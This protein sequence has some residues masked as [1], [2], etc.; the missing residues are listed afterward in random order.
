VKRMMILAVVG[1]AAIAAGCTSTPVRSN[2]DAY[3]ELLSKQQAA[4]SNVIASIAGAA[5]A[6]TDSRCVEHVA[7]MAAMAAAGGRGSNPIAPPPRELSGAEKFAQVF[8]AMS[9]L[10]GTVVT[11]AV[12][13][14]QSDNAARTAEAQYGYLD[15]VLGQALGGM[16]NVAGNAVPSITVGGNY[17]DTFGDNY[18]GGD[19]TQTDVAGHLIS[20]DS[21]VIGDRNYNSGRQDSAGPYDRTCTGDGCQPVNPDPAGGG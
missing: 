17:G 18:T 13:W 10:F 8:S 11:G 7:S 16:A 19:R 6:C 12:Q 3:G 1:F 2:Y 5:N 20:G 4:E 9:P 15:S 14:R 21:T